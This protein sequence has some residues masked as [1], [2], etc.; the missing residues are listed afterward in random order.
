[1]SV[2]SF[3]QWL[4]QTSVSIGIRESIWTYPI[5]E[6]THVLGLCLF[7]GLVI[8]LDLRLIGAIFRG[9]R[10]SQ[11]Q[12]RLFPWQMAGLAIMVVTGG[13]LFWADPVRFYQN[14]FFWAKIS[15][16]MLA[17]V[18]MLAFHFTIYKT[19]DVW[20]FDTVTPVRARLAGWF[21]IV[22]WAGVVVSGRM[23]TYNWFD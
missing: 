16:L 14:V 5:V 7:L 20:D 13:L 6:S 23:I 9:V 15:F 8:V 17:G 11:V 19:V 21:S 18:N 4:E 2:V 12:G 10:V 22:F 3:L 1:M